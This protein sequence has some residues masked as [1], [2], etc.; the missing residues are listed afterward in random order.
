MKVFLDV[1][2]HYG[3]TAEVALDPAWGFDAVHAFEPAAACQ[4]ILRGYR[5]R[6]LH[7]HPVALSNRAGR[8]PLFG[9]GLL[10]GSVYADKPQDGRG[11]TRAEEITLEPAAAWLLRHC[12]AE[13]EVYL[14][15]NCEGS[16]CDVLEDLLDARLD[17]WLRAVYVD[18]DVRKVPSQARR[19]TQVED[20][21]RAAG[22]AYTTP[23][24]LRAPGAAGV[25]QWLT[26]TCTRRGAG[27]A[28]ARYRLGLHRPLY[29]WQRTIARAALP[30]P[31]YHWA[32]TRFGAMSRSS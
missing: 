21:L 27:L 29:T 11:S 23:D 19:Q 5:D 28:T 10:G 2:A 25:A 13:D 18:F 12:S 1:G 8:V 24:D 7:V 30:A 22:V 26:R 20:R 31:L 3:E 6:R 4:P 15:L 32:A 9:A 14:K 17:P 16:E